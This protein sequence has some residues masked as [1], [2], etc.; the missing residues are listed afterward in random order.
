MNVN[1]E[2]FVLLTQG[3][4]YYYPDNVDGFAT[5]AADYEY[6]K[7]NVI[8]LD[9]Y[10]HGKLCVTVDKFTTVFELWDEILPKVNFGGIANEC[11]TPCFIAN[12]HIISVLSK[13]YLLDNFM[14]KYIKSS[15]LKAIFVMNNAAGDVF[16]D[17][18]LR[19]YFNS[20]EA[21]KHH[22]PHIHVDYFHEKS[23]VYSILTGERMKGNIPR[24]ID[25]KIK[26]R[27]MNNQRM[28]AEWWNN[29]TDG[30][31]IDLNHEFGYRNIYGDGIE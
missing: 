13:D 25:K 24:K 1:I 20:H 16:R 29:Q 15:T 10:I 2:Y 3:D 18:G 6:L 4:D 9:D 26:E 12:K 5:S 30:I 8:N 21:G 17:D 28:L 22:V 11:K 7:C 23:G 14:M 31:D 19:Y 27:I